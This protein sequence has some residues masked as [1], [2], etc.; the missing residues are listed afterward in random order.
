MSNI[1]E[2]L[3]AGLD[4]ITGLETQAGN[5]QIALEASESQR[6]DLQAKI[7]HMIEQ[8]EEWEYAAER[9]ICAGMALDALGVPY[10]FGGE[11]IKG[12]DCSG[13]TQFLYK[14]GANVSLPRVSKDQAKFGTEVNKD[15]QSTWRRGD[16]VFFDYSGDGVVDHVG[17]YIENGQ[18]LH[19]NTPTTGINIKAVTG[20]EKA[21]TGVRRV[22]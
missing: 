17:I 13:F 21:C 15:D 14:F 5:L 20:K 9:V 19:T 4:F 8:P 10:V 6:R 12:M 22:L 16:L 3:Q 18:M 7:E 11:T 1:K 2:S